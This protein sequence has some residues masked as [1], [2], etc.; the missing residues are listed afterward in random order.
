NG[1]NYVL[2]YANLNDTSH[3]EITINKSTGYNATFFSFNTNSV[4]S[5]EPEA[6]KWDLN[7]TV[8]TN[9]IDGFGSYAFSDGV[10][11]N[12]K[13]GVTAYSVTT[14]QY[15]YADFVYYYLI[16]NNFKYEQSVI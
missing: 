2:Q 9:I 3:Q 10:L 14:D 1:D 15:Y 11:N 16:E 8:F 13:G 6:D 5:V 12:R 7:F 4:V